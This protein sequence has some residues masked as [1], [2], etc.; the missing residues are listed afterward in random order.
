VLAGRLVARHV[1]GGRT[2]EDARG[3]VADHDLG[4]ARLVAASASRADARIRL[5]DERG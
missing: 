5:R 3:R 4:N 1:A 2:A